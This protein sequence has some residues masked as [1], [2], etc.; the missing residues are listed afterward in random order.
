[1][2]YERHIDLAVAG[3]VAALT[4]W[5]R[6]RRERAK[7]KIRQAFEWSAFPYLALS[8]GKD[9]VAMLGLVNDVARKMDRDFLC[10]LHVSDASFPGTEET[11][12]EACYRAGRKLVID[13]SPVSA[14]EVIGKQSR[15]KFGKKGYF[16]D[17]VDRMA[18]EHDMVF[19]G[20]RAAESKRRREACQHQGMIFKSGKIWKCHPL[21]YF[22]IEDVAAA[23]YEYRMPIHPIYSKLQAGS[24]PIRL[25]YATALDLVE[26]GT[27][28]FLRANYP[29]LFRKLVEACPDVRRYL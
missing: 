4:D 1:M 13:R 7:A 26:K 24:L 29:E 27:V 15:Q 10:W 16:F 14:F 22:S 19:V 11:A 9:S 6:G 17:S 20:V 23:I 21:A 12:V 2:R 18:E 8:G 28:V 25:G 3:P 5:Y